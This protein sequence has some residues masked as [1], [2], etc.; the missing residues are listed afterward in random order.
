MKGTLNSVILVGN[1][2]QEPT[3]KN[4]NGFDVTKFTIST[5]RTKGSKIKGTIEEVEDTIDVTVFGQ[6]GVY[7][8]DNLYL[9]DKV[10]VKGS[11][12]TSQYTGKDGERKSFTQ[13]VGEEVQIIEAKKK[14]AKE[15]S[16]SSGNDFTDDIPF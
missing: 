2:H 1:L 8:R 16:E 12:Q 15:K 4:Y 11:L 6:Q 10:V 5:I 13:V 9:G 7:C 14:E 3:S